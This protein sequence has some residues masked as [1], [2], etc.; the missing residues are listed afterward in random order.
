MATDIST[1]EPNVMA[2]GST[3]AISVTP[4]NNGPEMMMVRTKSAAPATALRAVRPPTWTRSQSAMRAPMM[5]VHVQN[6]TPVNS[7]D[8][9]VAPIRIMMAVHP[10]SWMTFSDAKMPAPFSP[11]DT[12]VDFMAG[13]SNRPPM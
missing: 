11:K 7:C 8:A 10:T 2:A 3:T 5:I 6:G 9:A 1:A 12:A 13:D 4:T